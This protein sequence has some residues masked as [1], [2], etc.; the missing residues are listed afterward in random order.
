M[1]FCSHSQ[2]LAQPYSIDPESRGAGFVTG[3][4]WT[5]QSPCGHRSSVLAQAQAGAPGTRVAVV[6]PNPISGLTS[7]HR[8]WESV[9]CPSGP[10]VS[11]GLTAF[12]AG[13]VYH[14]PWRGV[15]RWGPR[16]RAEPR[17]RWDAGAPRAWPGPKDQETPS[18]GLPLACRV[19]TRHRRPHR[20]RRGQAGPAR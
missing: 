13:S 16:R 9:L 11:S 7:R 20:F 15:G 17:R 18:P 3:R 5:G 19:L 8:V 6:L 2:V 4:R 12:S 14:G 1:N 10:S